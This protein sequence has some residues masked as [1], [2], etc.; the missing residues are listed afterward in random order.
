MLSSVATCLAGFDEILTLQWGAS[1][2]R[3][4]FHLETYGAMLEDERGFV[5]ILAR[6]SAQ[7][8]M[9]SMTCLRRCASRGPNLL[10]QSNRCSVVMAA[11]FI[12]RSAWSS[13]KIRCIAVELSCGTLA[14]W[15]AARS[16]KQITSTTTAKISGCCRV[17]YC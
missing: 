1:R 13:E 6:G 7:R 2:I 10:S 3:R 8:E 16:R 12:C 15:L 11:M 5:K 4:P 17:P 9:R 14:C